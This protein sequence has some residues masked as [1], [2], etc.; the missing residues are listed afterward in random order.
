M[1][2][3][4][5]GGRWKIPIKSIEL[6]IVSLFIKTTV[7]IAEGHKREW[8]DRQKETTVDEGCTNIRPVSE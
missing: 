3:N 1:I 7:G 4:Y 5:G 6:I 2:H 8:V